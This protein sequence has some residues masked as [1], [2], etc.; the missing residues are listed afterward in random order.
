[1]YVGILSSHSTIYI[2]AADIHIWLKD[3]HVTT[4]SKQ[5]ILNFVSLAVCFNVQL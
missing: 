5:L 4:Q 1:M 2:T 3:N